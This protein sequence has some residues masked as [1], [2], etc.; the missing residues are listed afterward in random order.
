VEAA[1][2][3]AKNLQNAIQRWRTWQAEKHLE[4]ARA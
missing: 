1:S 3:C 2:L 4:I